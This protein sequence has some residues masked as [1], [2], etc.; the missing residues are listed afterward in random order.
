[1]RNSDRVVSRKDSTP[2][3]CSKLRAHSRS[4]TPLALP[5]PP[6]IISHSAYVLSWFVATLLLL[7]GIY[8]QGENSCYRTAL[9]KIMQAD[10]DG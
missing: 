10:N 1:M 3:Q 8:L 9:A 5:R 7:Y 4:I 6:S 2:G